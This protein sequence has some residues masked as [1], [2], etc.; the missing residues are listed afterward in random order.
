VTDDLLEAGIGSS[1]VAALPDGE[2]ELDVV[3]VDHD[4]PTSDRGSA[5]P[6]RRA[7]VCEAADGTAW[8]VTL[9]Y[10][11]TGIRERAVLRTTV[12]RA[13]EN[14]LTD[15]AAWDTVS[16]DIALAEADAQ[17]DARGEAA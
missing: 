4:E 15:G 13:I 16:A 1:I 7:L 5:I 3:D 12:M 9:I 10:E 11:Y 8:R 2:T 17:A 14:T 6:G